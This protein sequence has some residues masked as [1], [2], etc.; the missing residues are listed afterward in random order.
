M[1]P[2]ALTPC[3]TNNGISLPASRTLGD[4]AEIAQSESDV[5][6][7][8]IEDK[9]QVVGV[10]PREAALGINTDHENG[11]HLGDIASKAYVYVREE[12]PFFDM[13][14]RMR[15]NQATVALVSEQINP[16]SIA[17]VKGLISQNQ[18]TITWKKQ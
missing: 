7:F 3:A 10:I 13:L 12:A 6:Y 9:Q 18:I 5:S 1:R 11:N 4:F 15:L 2:E 17:E 16:Q 14:N 8:I